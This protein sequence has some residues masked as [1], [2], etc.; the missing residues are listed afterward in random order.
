M[1]LFVKPLRG[2]FR[3]G[4]TVP[5]ILHP[6]RTGIPRSARL[7]GWAGIKYCSGEYMIC[8]NST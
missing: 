8:K 2:I 4:V 6:V 1:P 3:I 7:T 5:T